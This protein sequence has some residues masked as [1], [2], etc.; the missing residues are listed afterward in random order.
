V[1]EEPDEEEAHASQVAKDDEDGE[2]TLLGMK[3]SPEILST[4]LSGM[5]AAEPAIAEGSEDDPEG[6]ELRDSPETSSSGQS[7]AVL[8]DGK[9]KG[10]RPSAPACIL[11]S[12][13]R[14]RL[15]RW[16]CKWV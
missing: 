2:N 9:P 5:S 14:S 7:D 8:S 11:R 3:T 12:V 13:G 16:V 15:N 10:S 1:P 6:A 4:A